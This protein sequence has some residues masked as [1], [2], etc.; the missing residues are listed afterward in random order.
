M[1]GLSWGLYR[2]GVGD[3]MISGRGTGPEGRG[4]L[5]PAVRLFG[6]ESWFCCFLV[7]VP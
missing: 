4:G 5:G 3:A 1:S 7:V 2:Q 6:L